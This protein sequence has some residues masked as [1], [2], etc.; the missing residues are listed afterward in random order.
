LYGLDT[1]FIDT[2]HTPLGITRNYSTVAH[3]HTIQFT[4][5]TAKPSL[6][7]CV[8]ISHSLA[9]ASNSGDPSASRAQVLPSPTLIQNCVPAIPSTE[10][11][12]LPCRAQLYTALS[13]LRSLLFTRTEEKTSFQTIPP[14]D[15]IVSCIFALAGTC[16]RNRCLKIDVSSGSTLPGI[17]LHVTLLLLLLLL[18]LVVVV[19]VVVVV[20][21]V[22]VVVLAVVVVVVV[23]EKSTVRISQWV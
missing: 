6:V 1:G 18:V 2:L 23:T 15:T 17:R 21:A 14:L 20:V 8:L 9:T 12:R 11:D 19:V 22:V 13:N 16:L 4:T 3:L 7:C 5:A 10:L